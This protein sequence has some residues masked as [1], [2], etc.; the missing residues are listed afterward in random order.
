MKLSMSTM[1]FDEHGELIDIEQRF[2]CLAPYFQN[3]VV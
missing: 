2:V 3:V 1:S